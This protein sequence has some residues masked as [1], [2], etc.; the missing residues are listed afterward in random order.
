MKNRTVHQEN[1][2]GQYSAKRKQVPERSEHQN[3]YIQ[4]SSR[5]SAHSK[6]GAQTAF[7]C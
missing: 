3:L 7:K 2:S 5:S 6:T 1:G 4:R